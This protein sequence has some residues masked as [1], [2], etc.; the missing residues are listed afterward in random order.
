MMFMAAAFAG[1]AVMSDGS[2]ATDPVVNYGFEGDDVIATSTSSTYKFTFT[3]SAELGT[4]SISYTATL[5][6]DGKAVSGGVSP[7]TGSLTSGVAVS[8]TVASQKDAGTY[9]LKV[10]VEE[11]VSDGDA[12]YN[13]TAVKE[14]RIIEPITLSVTINNTG[15]TDLYKGKVLFYLDGQAID[16]SEKELNLTAGSSTTVTYDYMPTELSAGKHTYY[17]QAVDGTVI[18]GIGA[19]NA[20]TFYYEQGDYSLFNYLLLLVIVIL[21]LLLVWVFRKPVKNFGKPKSRR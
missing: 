15:S 12:T 13:Y 6:K 18:D 19:D 9:K 14:I 2:D 10:E 8:L 1:I 5:E 11:K 3:E 7:S 16:G 4:L 20:V 17:I 21:L